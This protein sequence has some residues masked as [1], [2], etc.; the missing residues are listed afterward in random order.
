MTRS[1][2]VWWDR[3]VVGSLA[4]DRH[5]TMRFAYAPRW[6]A[7]DSA[8]PVSFSL[9]KRP[10]SFSTRECLPFFEG[11]L[12]E[13]AQ[14]DAVAAALGVSPANP[15]GLLSQLGAEVAGALSLL[16]EGEAPPPRRA[17][18]PPEPLSA[19]AL[20]QLLDTIR[21]RP[22]LAARRGTL[23]LSLAGAQSKMPVIAINSAV[24]LPSP[25]QPSTHI[26]KPSSARFPSLTENE[27]FAMR[28]A[29]RMGLSVAPVQPGV[30]ASR[31]FLLVERYDRRLDGDGTIK[32]LHQEDFCQA[33][34]VPPAQKY[35]SEGGPTFAQCFDLVRRVCTRPAR[36]VLKLLDAAILQMLLGNADAHGKNYSLLA[37]P[38]GSIE[39][40][41]LYDLLSTIAYPDLS[42]T[43]A[44]KIAGRG[45]LRQLRRGDWG[46]FAAS[47]S[48]SARFVRRRVRELC[49]YAQEEVAATVAELVSPG[50]REEA[51]AGCAGRVSGRARRLA[52]SV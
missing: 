16:P 4:L 48:L 45:S 35:A 40:A 52:E 2:T 26:L 37:R 14:R 47:A 10:A 7:E 32:R 25:G 22:F 34:G 1:L 33:L 19:E 36:E 38:D 8:P 39:V 6:L 18:E 42:P 24:A 41:P 9:P 20:L 46:R 43:L 31:S 5:G 17:A 44:M 23:R 30:V 28:L 49:G 21:T 3:N 29:S 11:L 50:L 27:A 15:F 12:P 13:G 51:L